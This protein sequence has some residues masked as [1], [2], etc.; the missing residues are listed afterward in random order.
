MTRKETI[1]GESGADEANPMAAVPRKATENRGAAVARGPINQ[2]HVK[3]VD[4]AAEVKAET[5]VENANEVGAGNGSDQSP[6]AH[7]ENDAAIPGSGAGVNGRVGSG[8][9]RQTGTC[10]HLLVFQG[11]EDSRNL[12]RSLRV[13]REWPGFRVRDTIIDKIGV[14]TR[15]AAEMRTGPEEMIVVM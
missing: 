2:D 7:A 10:R 14:E 11:R 3:D 1:R 12:V 9:P 6:V 15:T 8:T 5:V 13:R 4:L